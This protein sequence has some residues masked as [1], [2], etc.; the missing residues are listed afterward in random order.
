MKKIFIS[1]SDEDRSR[2]RSLAKIIENSNHFT[3]IIIADRRDALTA[4]TEKVKIG[5]FES[6]YIV[7]LLTKNSISSQWVNQEI[8]YAAAL[9]KEIIPIINKEIINDLK[10]FVHKNIDL[11]YS[12]L[13]IESNNK[14]TRNSFRDACNLAITDLLISNN[15]A[16]KTLELENIFP[17][18]WTSEFKGPTIEGRELDIKISEG[19]KYHIKGKHWFNIEKFKVSKDRK[20]VKFLK[21]GIGTDTRRIVNDLKILKL[22]QVYAGTERDESGEQGYVNIT[23]KRIL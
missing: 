14:K 18:L 12:F 17:G 16:A 4:L 11:P 5:I 6:D 19:N 3:S 22:G 21:V 15:L 10:G 13:E 7:P 2:M 1:Y 20:K 23:Y 8:G 9:N